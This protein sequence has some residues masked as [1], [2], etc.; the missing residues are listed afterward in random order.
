MKKTKPLLPLFKKFISESETGKRLKK[1]GERITSGSIQNYRA[2]YNNLERFVGD[3][4]FELRI[5]DAKRLNS[6]EY[7]SEK[8]YWKKFYRHFTSFLYKRGCFDNYVGF[9]IKT[10]K[11]FLIYLKYDKDFDTGDFHKLFYVRKQVIEVNVLSVEQLKYLIH[12]KK[13]HSKLNKS[14][15]FVKD[16]F[17]FGCYTGLRFSDIFKL[18]ENNFVR[19]DDSLYLRLRSQ[20]TKTFISLKLSQEAISVYKNYNIGTARKP[21]FKDTNLSYFND[22]LKRIG[23]IACF[24][25][26]VERIREQQGKVK[27]NT[28]NQKKFHEI[29]SSHMMRRTAITTLL[30]L[31]MPEHLVKKISGHS[32]NSK[33]FGRYVHY[34]Q[35]FVDKE[36]DKVHEKLEKI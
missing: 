4:D 1:N 36:M 31:G 12:N 30:V 25:A 13:F 3:K 19:D 35:M 6:R 20:K 29:M 22:K 24:N 17:I 28:K 7:I 14:Q 8:N 26:P 2:V 5:C 16:I 33:S 32:A 23:Q 11:T 10:I 21:V 27:R 9:N 15:T 18:T 34:A